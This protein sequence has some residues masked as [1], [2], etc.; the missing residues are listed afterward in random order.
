M[1]LYGY[2]VNTLERWNRFALVLV[3]RVT[4]NTPIADLG[5][6]LCFLLP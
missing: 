1:K 6:A 4:N 5:L 3:Q 2:L